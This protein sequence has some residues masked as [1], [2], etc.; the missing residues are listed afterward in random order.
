M[1]GTQESVPWGKEVAGW[2]CI[3]P[4][5]LTLKSRGRKLK[6]WAKCGS[7]PFFIHSILLG[8][9]DAH[10]FSIAA[11]HDSGKTENIDYPALY[12]KNLP[13]AAQHSLANIAIKVIALRR[14]LS[15]VHEF[16]ES[17][18]H[19]QTI[20]KGTA[21]TVSRGLRIVFSLWEILFLGGSL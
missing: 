2:L 11:P 10:L 21:W 6:P 8:C 5:Y 14:G 3:T 16:G 12:C 7:P 1:S 9:S 18:E 19:K 13:S 4:S 15:N 20:R 17:L